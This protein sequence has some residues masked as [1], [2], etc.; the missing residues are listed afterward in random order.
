MDSKLTFEKEYKAWLIELKQKVY[1]AQIKAIIKVNSE[2]LNLYWDIGKMIVEKQKNTNWGD[3]L[4]VNLSK[5]LSH[6]FPEIKGFSRTNLL[7]IRQWYLFYSQI[8]NIPQAVGQNL[9]TYKGLITQ[10]PWGHNREIISKCKTKE[11]ALFY[12][13]NTLIHNWSRSILVHKIETNLYTS[14]GKSINNFEITLPKPQSDLANQTLK[15]PYIFDFLRL[16]DDYNEKDLENALTKHLTK[17]LLELGAGFSFVGRQYHLEIGREDFYID[18]LFYHLKLRC[19]IVIEIKTVPFKPEFAGK[20]NFYLSAVDDL[21]KHENDN[22]SIGII[23]CKDKNK[24]VAE[25]SLRDINKPVGIAEYKLT[26][27]L[28]EDLKGSLPSIEEIERSLAVEETKK[29]LEEGK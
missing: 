24:L 12:I 13:K 22:P 17:F 28:P 7:Y 21:L 27:L 23:L 26:E 11:E 8:E 18:L 5:D 20:L 16:S 29:Y 3:K 9:A 14:E 6:E 1:S 4:I 25:Y 19:Y 10:I 2:L 15:D